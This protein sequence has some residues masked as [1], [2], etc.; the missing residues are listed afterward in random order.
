MTAL[1]NAAN[2]SN[3]GSVEML[4]DHG[5]DKDLKN[6]EGKTALDYAKK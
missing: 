3:K 2:Y 5:A 4:L 6:S 1:M